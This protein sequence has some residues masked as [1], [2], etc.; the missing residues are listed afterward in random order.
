IDRKAK[1]AILAFRIERSLS[2]SRILELYLNEI[3][4]GYGSYG[5]AAAALNY[6]EKPLSA[7]TIGDAAYL[8]ALP[9]APNHYQPVR[10]H[11]A[12]GG[13]WDWVSDAGGSDGVSGAVEADAVRGEPLVVH[14]TSAS[15]VTSADDF[16]E[17]V[18]RDLLRQFGETALYE[19]GLSVR[20]SIEPRLQA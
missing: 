14:D 12:A 9:N 17:E 5:V 2:K 20:T 10:R 16:A 7:L 18:R 8:A 6:F 1:E 19:G 15:D 4:L 13:R 11:A 3:Y